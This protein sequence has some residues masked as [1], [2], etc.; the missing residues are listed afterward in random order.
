M[1]Y[2][3]TSAP[4]LHI[5]SLI[6]RGLEVS[7]GGVMYKITYM[8]TTYGEIV[9]CASEYATALTNSSDGSGKISK[10]SDR[11]PKLKADGRNLSDYEKVM[12]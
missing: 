6:R 4:P 10:V 5:L 12:S 1:S 8:V 2:T 3:A 11:I 7:D 9:I